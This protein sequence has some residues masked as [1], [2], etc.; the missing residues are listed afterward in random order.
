MKEQ[1]KQGIIEEV[2]EL[3][4]STKTSYL[5]HQAVIRQETET[6]K[7]RIVYDASA[8][9]GKHRI[10]VN[11]CLHVDPLPNPLLFDIFSKIQRE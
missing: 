2:S 5:P 9:E 7:L 10:S 6:T 1:S 8:K 4:T 11:D 3:E